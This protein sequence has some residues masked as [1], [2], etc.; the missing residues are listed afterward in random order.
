MSDHPKLT[1]AQQ[2]AALLDVKATALAR[3]DD[4]PD[5]F[6]GQQSL[7]GWI[8]RQSDKAVARVLERLAWR[9]RVKEAYAETGLDFVGDGKSA[10]M[11]A[12][13]LAFKGSEMRAVF[14]ALKETGIAA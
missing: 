4:V 8:S 11:R 2:A 6:N 1:T 10:V 7:G 14:T 12:L 3:F 13:S 9:N 5:Y